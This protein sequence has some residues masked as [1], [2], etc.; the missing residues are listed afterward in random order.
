MP[1]FDEAHYDDLLQP[2]SIVTQRLAAAGSVAVNLPHCSR[3]NLRHTDEIAALEAAFPKARSAALARAIR[4]AI[5]LKEEAHALCK[6]HGAA[7]ERERDLRLQGADEASLAAAKEAECEAE[8]LW[9]AKRGELEAAALGVLEAPVC[10]PDDI[11]LRAEAFADL[12]GRPAAGALPDCDE[13]R[14]LMLSSYRAAVEEMKARQPDRTAWDAAEKAL[15]DAEWRLRCAGDEEDSLNSAAHVDEG[16]REDLKA[17]LDQAYA[18]RDVA[19]SALLALDPPD[20]A[21]LLVQMEIVFDHAAVGDVGTHASRMRL[22]GEEPIT[23]EYLW[24]AEGE[25]LWPAFALLAINAAKLADQ[26]LPRDW[27]EFIDGTGYTHENFRDAIDQAIRGGQGPRDIT[28]IRLA[29]PEGDYKL[30]VLTFG[31]EK[32]A[33][34]NP[35]GCW[36]WQPVDRSAAEA[37]Q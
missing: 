7:E 25:A 14:E 16:V 6:A 11:I 9:N 21:A 37:V 5:P 26:S 33:F 8:D 1:N 30:P 23:A 18:D 29:G 15:R 20:A 13:D 32:P 22:R 3:A 4:N 27:K 12:V 34:A 17:R 10:G 28:S 2:S 24:A 35:E 19:R 31:G 36:V